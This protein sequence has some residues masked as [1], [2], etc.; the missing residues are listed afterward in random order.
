MCCH[1]CICT[2]MCSCMCSQ[3]HT[4]PRMCSRLCSITR[5]GACMCAHMED[6][7]QGG[8]WPIKL[9]LKKSQFDRLFSALG[10]ISHMWSQTCISAHMCAFVCSKTCR[11]ACIC[12]KI[13]TYKK[14]Y[15]I[16]TIL[17]HQSNQH[18]RH[19]LPWLHGHF[20]DA[21]HSLRSGRKSAPPRLT[22]LW[23]VVFF[24]S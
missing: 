13:I 12:K 21:V 20:G 16:K 10:D 5:M 8:E 2:H 18:H 23:P 1:T 4:F 15:S 6:F 7:T 22:G 24:L 17:Q 19:F 9:A 3:A 11:W 14:N